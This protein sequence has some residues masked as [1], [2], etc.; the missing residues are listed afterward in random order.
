MIIS[1]SRRTDI[2]A[3]YAEWFERRVQEGFLYVR[4]PM[5]AH[6]VSEVTLSPSVVD[7]IV[8]WTKNP[9]PLM[10]RLDAFAAYRYYFQFT[11][12]GYGRDVEPNVPDKKAE[13]IPAFQRL[14]DKV[15]A[16][17]VIWRYDPIAFTEKYTPEYHL[18]AFEQIASLLQGRT[19]RCVISFVDGYACNRKALAEMGSRDVGDD[20]LLEFCKRLSTLAHEHGMAVGSCAE[21][22]DL[23]GVG[24]EHNACIDKKLIERIEGCDLR[25]DKDKSQ[26]VECGCFASI[27][28][29]T[30][31]TCGAGCKYCYA[32][33]SERATQENLR[34]YDPAS[35]LLCDAL[36]PDD[37]VRKR[38]MRSLLVGPVQDALF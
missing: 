35:P 23:S 10:E 17:R 21:K 4:N 31:N 27:D 15:G 20:R 2:P 7:C 32:R 38:D 26:R 25:V 11:L 28:I 30:Y 9:I 33:R 29:G 36:G 5:N 1:A 14:S 16:E 22:I 18:R 34:R 19:E 13:L 37:V 12:T 3:F 24:I 8:F 6:Q